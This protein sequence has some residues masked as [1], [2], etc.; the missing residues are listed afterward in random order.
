MH[1]KAATRV[2]T[3]LIRVRSNAGL[4][5][6]STGPLAH[7]ASRSLGLRVIRA[8]E[9]TLFLAFEGF[10]PNNLTRRPVCGP[11]VRVQDDE[12]RAF[13]CC[14][15]EDFIQSVLIAGVPCDSG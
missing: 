14:L 11:A 15:V 1:A 9:S 5:A 2:P 12:L 10:C 6:M 7:A 8:T 4:G 3:T 13:R